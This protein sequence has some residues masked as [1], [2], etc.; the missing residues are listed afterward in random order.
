MEAAFAPRKAGEPLK[1]NVPKDIDESAKKE[2]TTILQ[3]HNDY[4]EKLRAP[5]REFSS[6][7]SS[8]VTLLILSTWM[9][10][11]LMLIPVKR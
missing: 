5:G 9:G 7:F 10:L 11:G 3:E 6:Q 8:T 1:L 4:K 2:W